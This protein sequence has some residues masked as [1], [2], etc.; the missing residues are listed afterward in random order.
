M[1][2]LTR[3]AGRLDDE[4]EESNEGIEQLETCIECLHEQIAEKH[5]WVLWNRGRIDLAEE[6]L[7]EIADVKKIALVAPDMIELEPYR[8]YVCR[9]NVRPEYE[10]HVAKPG[11]FA[12]NGKVLS[13][14][15]LWEFDDDARY[16]GEYA[17]ASPYIDNMVLMNAGVAWIP[18][19]DVDVIGWDGGHVTTQKPDVEALND[20]PDEVKMKAGNVYRCRINLRPEYDGVGVRQELAGLNGEVVNLLRG[21]KYDDDEVYHGEWQMIGAD[22]ATE[23]ILR[24]FGVV[25]ISSGDVEVI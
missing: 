19:G 23:H 8:V 6:M 16:H 2:T 22:L 21:R 15:R 18:S 9:I 7:D 13:L 12:L 11:L 1:T 17:M 25:C 14:R 20:V 5:N 10:G 3:L 24:G 4:I